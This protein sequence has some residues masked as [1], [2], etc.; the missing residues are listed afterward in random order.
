M[1][2]NV[3]RFAPLPDVLELFL[4][5]CARQE[6]IL[7]LKI[8][9]LAHVLLGGVVVVARRNGVAVDSE[10]GKIVVHLLELAMSVSL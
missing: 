5:H 9:P 10:P 1:P 4:G 8:Q 2:K 7:R 3:Y 6:K